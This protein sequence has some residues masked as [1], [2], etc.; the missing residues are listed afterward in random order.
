MT[1]ID[2][3]KITC[4]ICKKICKS[5]LSI[6]KHIQCNH[7]I[8]NTKKFLF[9]NYPELFK[10]CK[11]CSVKIKYYVNDTQARIYCSKNCYLLSINGKKQSP[12][13]IQKRIKN[14]DQITKEKHRQETFINRYGG[15]YAPHDPLQRGQNISNALKGV[16]HTKEHHERVIESKKI[17]GTLKHTEETKQKISKI[18]TEIFNSPNFDKSIFLSNKSSYNYGYYKNFYCRSSYEKKF[19]DFCEFFLIEVE[20]AETNNFSVKYN[21]NY[22]VTRTYF[23]DFYLPSFDLVVEIKPISMINYGNNIHKFRAAE[24]CFKFIVITEKDY[25]LDDNNWHLLYDKL[26]LMI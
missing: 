2:T 7:F 13:T 17:N 24:L 6:S 1:L 18:V 4:L 9:E 11:R 21:D 8:S 25:L 20:S 16:K 14:T 15:L 22:G 3:T 12:E 26:L 5:I 10:K 19:I 23:P